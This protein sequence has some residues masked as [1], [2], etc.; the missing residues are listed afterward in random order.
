MA[1]STANLGSESD[2]SALELSKEQLCDAIERT[3]NCYLDNVS[4]TSTTVV[5]ELIM[6]ELSSPLHGQDDEKEF[7]E[8]GDDAAGALHMAMMQ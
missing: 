7:I 8:I 1:A 2:S 5:D 6:V 3:N 4:K